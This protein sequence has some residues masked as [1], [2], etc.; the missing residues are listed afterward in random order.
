[1][2]IPQKL[3]NPTLRTEIDMLVGTLDYGDV[4][5]ATSTM[6]YKYK[7]ADPVAIMANP[8]VTSPAGR[9]KNAATR[10]IM[11]LLRNPAPSDSVHRVCL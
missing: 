1:M 9:S 6:G 4:R 8:T 2:G 11:P 5:V 3:A 7:S 10:S